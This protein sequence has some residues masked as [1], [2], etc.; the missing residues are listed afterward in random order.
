V[1]AV[2][3]EAG[4]QATPVPATGTRLAAFR[5]AIYPVAFPLVFL[6]LFWS[7]T[8][9]DPQTIVRSLVIG[10]VVALAVSFVAC[11]IAGRVRGGLAAS[12][13]LV[14]LLAP[15]TTIAGPVLIVVG[16]GVLVEGAVHRSRP[17]RHAALIDRVM[18]SLA[19][20]LLLAVAIQ[21]V[22]GGALARGI[23][24]LQLDNLP[25][26][27]PTSAA[28]A[29]ADNDPDIVM[30]MLDGFPGD[31]AAKLATQ[32]GSPYDP[33]AFPD[34]LEGLGFHVQRNSHS[35]YL[36]TPMT[37]ASLLDMRHLVDI[38]SL[39]GGG[40]EVT[41]GRGFR[42]VADEGR[43]LDI[44]HDH[45]Y[46]L[47]WVDGGFSH[48]EIRR[49][50]RWIDH[51]TPTELEVKALSETVLGEALDALAPDLLSSLQRDRI[52]TTIGDARRLIAEPHD[53]PRFAFVH[54]PAPHAPW[55]FGANGEPRTE[56]LDSFFV[57]P[58]G[59]RNIDRAEAVRRVFAQATYVADQTLDV[60]EDLVDRPDPPVVVVISDHGPGTEID[61][62]H[63]ATTD[64]VERSSNFL[65]TFTPG[66][67]H[68]F[69][70]FTTPVNVF[71]T[72]FDGYFGMNVP[73]AA[74]T[75]YA[76][77]GL[78]VNLFPVTVPGTNS[79]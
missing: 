40:G 57:D 64:L 24:D 59:N 58:V 70:G 39:R 32:S 31:A 22:A 69:D 66:Q 71:P 46:E 4:A 55:I 20:I 27:S 51:G 75:I 38:P 63:P 41:G 29:A 50:D 13:I 26:P 37:L 61:F 48:I 23:A 33:D 14:G 79:R 53:A 17:P 8:N 60:L 16:I 9:A 34:A 15:S 2:T 62:D 7:A 10:S 74:D 47:V 68:L 11:L 45:G 56:R 54:V 19:S 44:L 43:A 6:L 52:T 49:V 18:L 77:K 35:N 67:P 36:I 73:K 72:L 21:I 12:A 30:I 65:A 78:Q 3:T 1:T 28:S 76:W 42:R 25:R 5:P